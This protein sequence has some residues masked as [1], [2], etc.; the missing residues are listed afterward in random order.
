MSRGSHSLRRFGAALAAAVSIAC[1]S[2]APASPTSTS[3]STAVTI[4]AT[5]KAHLDN[6]VDRMQT[7]W[8]FRSQM[9]WP[10]FRESVLYEARTAQTIQDTYPAI[11][12]ALTLLGDRHSYYV[13]AG[14]EFIFNPHSPSAFGACA[15]NP[16]PPAPPRFNDIGY[17]KIQ[18]YLDGDPQERARAIQD[19]IRAEDRAGLAG[20]IVDMRNSHGGNMWPTL[21]G[22][23]SIIGDGVAG[24]FIGPGSVVAG[25]WGYAGSAAF[26]NS[27]NVVTLAAPVQLRTPN[28]RVAVLTDL[29][30]SSSGEAIT[31][32]FRER[33]NTRSFGRSTCGLST[34]VGQFTLNAGGIIGIVTARMADRTKRQFGE[35]VHPDEYIENDEAMVLR[36]V[37]W[38]RGQ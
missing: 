38:L 2:K 14:G 24:Y 25:E 9:S 27:A 32:A 26:N 12:L 35:A 1:G 36:A 16:A 33:P 11:Q 17:V 21:A 10:A 31:I 34:A 6:I 37:A 28:P 5:A 18:V 15:A 4:S 3:T 13:T 7:Q 23:G 8:Y 29:G 22:L 20:W 19:A 30:V